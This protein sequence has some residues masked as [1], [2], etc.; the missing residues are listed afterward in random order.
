MKIILLISIFLIEI[1]ADSCHQ[2]SICSSPQPSQHPPHPQNPVKRG[3]MG[4]RGQKGEKGERGSDVGDVEARVGALEGENSKLREAIGELNRTATKQEE[5]I[6]K[7]QNLIVQ[8]SDQ[9]AS[10]VLNQEKKAKH[11]KKILDKQSN[12]ISTISDLYYTL[13]EC[14]VPPILNINPNIPV[15]ISHNSSVELSCAPFTAVGEINRNCLSGNWIPSFRSE[16][17]KCELFGAS[18]EAAN[19]NC[20]QIGK[21]LLIDD[22]ET[23]KKRQ[24][25]CKKYGVTTD[26]LWTGIKK[27]GREWVKADGSVLGS[28]MQIDWCPGYPTSTNGWDYPVIYCNENSDREFGRFK[29]KPKS[30][31]YKFICQ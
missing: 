5:N 31:T 15:K 8:L 22:I 19:T 24:E 6:S 16:P 1:S 26:R 4:A 14:H 12:E 27:Y 21:K 10:S 11:L 17:F 2:F 30:Y 25:L 3:K 13:S 20:Q 7:M 28:N 29:N 18:W 9:V 23:T